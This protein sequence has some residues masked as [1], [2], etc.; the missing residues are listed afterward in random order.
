MTKT[1]CKGG[2]DGN[3]LMNTDKE[4]IWPEGESWFDLTLEGEINELAYHTE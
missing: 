2:S 4:N 3:D 1:K